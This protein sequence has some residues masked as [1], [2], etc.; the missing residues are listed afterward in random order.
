MT[1]PS[2]NPFGI[3]ETVNSSNLIVNLSASLFAFCKIIQALLTFSRTQKNYQNLV[4]FATRS[5]AA[6]I[7]P[8][9]TERS[10]H[11]QLVQALIDI[12]MSVFGWVCWVRLCSLSLG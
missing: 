6:S 8:S 2:D 12:V 11:M 7:R 9:S 10:S 5:L 3:I 1:I 4:I